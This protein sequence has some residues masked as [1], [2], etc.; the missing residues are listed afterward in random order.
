MAQGLLKS[1]I[2]PLPKFL[3]RDGEDLNRFLTQFE[4]T[5]NRFSYPE[6]EKL[7]LLKQQI[8][9]RALLLVDSLEADKQ[10]YTQAKILLQS[11][12]ASP[13]TQ[14]FNTIKQI[15]EMKLTYENDPFEY[16]SKMRNLTES[17]KN[18]NIDAESF[19]QYFFWNGLNDT[20]KN[21][22]VQITNTT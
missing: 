6:Y 12:L 7:L 20:F 22:I 21:Q 13:D 15:S 19:L 5:I 14:R 10:S 1:P 8:S 11:A 3:S 17:V 16:I 2:A 4:E 9:G 18:L